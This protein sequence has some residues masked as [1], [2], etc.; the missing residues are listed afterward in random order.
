MTFK[1][2][3]LTKQKLP[4]ANTPESLRERER[5]ERPER[6]MGGGREKESERESQTVRDRVAERERP[7]ERKWKTGTP[8]LVTW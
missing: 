8:P 6:V 3:S 7:R 5:K 2:V 1:K 4:L